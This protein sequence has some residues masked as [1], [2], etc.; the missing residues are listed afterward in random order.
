MFNARELAT[1][2]AA[3]TFWKEEISH[4]GTN[5]AWPYFDEAGVARVEPLS[6]DEID[7]VSD[8]LRALHQPD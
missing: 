1:I 3:L 7:R 5:F 2:L 8:R 4:F 6:I